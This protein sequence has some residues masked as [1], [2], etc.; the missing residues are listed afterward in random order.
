MG[1]DIERLIG[2]PIDD[3]QTAA[4]MV[5][6]GVP[7]YLADLPSNHGY[8]SEQ[9]VLLQTFRD[10]QKKERVRMIGLMTASYSNPIP[11]GLSTSATRTDVEAALGTPDHVSPHRGTDGVG[12]LYFRDDIQIWINIVGSLRDIAVRDLDKTE[13]A[14]VQRL[15]DPTRYGKPPQAANAKVLRMR[16]AQ[17]SP[18][19]SSARAMGQSS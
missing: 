8:F 2:L 14:M 5:A 1:E 13:H 3:P 17:R 16:S 10:S 7:N 11:Y 4:F 15:K 18:T 19:R 6:A 12:L 9:G